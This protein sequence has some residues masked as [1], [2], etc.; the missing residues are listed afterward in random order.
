M[1][2]G[3]FEP[4]IK[5]H[6]KLISVRQKGHCMDSVHNFDVNN[7]NALR[8]CNK[9]HVWERTKNKESI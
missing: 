8:T 3:T 2:H 6:K 4:K 1:L 9:V 5:E 7:F